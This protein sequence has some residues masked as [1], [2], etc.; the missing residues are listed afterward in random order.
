M[1]K[2]TF[3]V[4]VEEDHTNQV[5]STVM[6]MKMMQGFGMYPPKFIKVKAVEPR[7]PIVYRD[8]DLSDQWLKEALWRADNDKSLGFMR[9]DARLIIKRLILEVRKLNRMLNR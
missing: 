1:A 9:R 4:T 2:K 6:H 8:P 7:E 3:I 5:N